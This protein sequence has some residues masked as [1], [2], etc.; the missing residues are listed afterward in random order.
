MKARFWLIYG[1]NEGRPIRPYVVDAGSYT[2]D[3][4]MNTHG[5]MCRNA[6][7]LSEKEYKDMPFVY[8]GEFHG[9]SNPVVNLI[10]RSDGFPVRSFAEF[11]KAAPSCF[12]LPALAILW[13]TY[14]PDRLVTLQADMLNDPIIPERMED[15][16]AKEVSR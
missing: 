10:V 5:D 8:G 3:Y 2:Y 6:W 7:G 13:K 15:D 1:L 11:E 16:F 14:G 12:S 4:H 9:P